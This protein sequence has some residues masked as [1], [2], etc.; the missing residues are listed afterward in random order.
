MSTP[1]KTLQAMLSAA[2]DAGAG[3]VAD[4]RTLATLTIERKGV[5]DFFSAA[6][7]KAEETV[8]RHL[9]AF[10]PTYGF[11]GEEGGLIPGSDPDHVWVVDPLDGT[12]NFLTNTP[13]WAVNIALARQG[14]V[15]AGV[16]WCPALNEMFRA[17]LGQGAFL[18]DKA[19]RVSTRDKLEDAVLAV[20]IPFAAKPEH[21]RFRNEM[22]ALTH[23]VAGIRRLGAGAI[24]LAWVSCGRFEA[25]WEQKVSAW[26]MGAGAILVREAGGIVTDT[27]G[28]PLDLHNGTVLGTNAI[29]HDQILEAIRPQ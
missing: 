20:G 26:D 22:A 17:E 28:G 24:D 8:R 18:N 15:I 25:Y 27:L 7:V 2:H 6:D 13:L 4:Q 14:E 11:L 9:E 29:L 5:S 12:T 3:L 1:S 23:R 19:I 21:E 10:A 16:T